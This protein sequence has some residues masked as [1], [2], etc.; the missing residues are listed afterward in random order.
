MIY[1]NNSKELMDRFAKAETDIKNL[2][3]RLDSFV[4]NVQNKTQVIHETNKYIEY[5]L[6]TL[7]EKGSADD[8]DKIVFAYEDN[9]VSGAYGIYGQT[10]HPRFL[11]SNNIFNFKTSVGPV[12]KDVATVKI[13]D[14]T[15]KQ[16]ADLLKD[17]AVLDQQPVFNLY[18]DN[19]VSLTITIPS[20]SSL[21]DREFNVIELCPFLPGSF[22]IVTMTITEEDG[23]EYDYPGDIEKCGCM[24]ICFPTKMQLKEI[25]FVFRLNYQTIGSLYPFGFRHIY[26]LNAD[27]ADSSIV[28]PVTKKSY[29][30]YISEEVSVHDQYGTHNTLNDTCSKWGIRAFMYF[31]NNIL[32]NEITPLYGSNQSY[33]SRNI[34]TFYLQIPISTSLI[35]MEFKKIDLR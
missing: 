31:N 35:S 33:I 7:A 25:S 22:D 9:I 12:Y 32:E 23:T 8:N 29:I 1:R 4:K 17:D 18:K 21:I 27:Y 34:K 20:D 15:K 30:N 11:N 13:N 14:D 6:N 16:Y 26:F 28:I 2:D 5:S 10:I 19:A 24:R 3:V